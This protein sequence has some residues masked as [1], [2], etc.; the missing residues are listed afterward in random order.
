M[1]H[2]TSLLHLFKLLHD[3]L[4]LKLYK[5]MYDISDHSPPT[6]SKVGINFL[7]KIL[8]KQSCTLT[9]N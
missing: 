8:F 4:V 9:K 5:K 3:T 7:N 6:A 1:I 2:I